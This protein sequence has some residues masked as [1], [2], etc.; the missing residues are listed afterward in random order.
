MMTSLKKCC[1]GIPCREDPIPV[2]EVDMNDKPIKDS[3]LSNNQ[4][5][6]SR[7]M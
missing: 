7:S 3:G 1:D 5:Y 2:E 6:F 4:D